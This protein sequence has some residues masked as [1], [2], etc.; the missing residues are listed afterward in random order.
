[1]RK[2]EGQEPEREEKEGK[3]KMWDTSVILAYAPC[4]RL[5]DALTRVQNPIF[6]LARIIPCRERLHSHACTHRDEVRVVSESSLG[7]TH[8]HNIKRNEDPTLSPVSLGICRNIVD[9]EASAD[10][11]DD[12]E[13]ILA[14]KVSLPVLHEA[15][16]LLFT[17]KH[18]HGLLHPPTK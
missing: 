8:D 9:E 5:D 2:S 3:R 7:K 16:T 4:Y 6:V 11:K 17:E 10:E 14:A 1:M 12:F 18:G 15:T 13:Q